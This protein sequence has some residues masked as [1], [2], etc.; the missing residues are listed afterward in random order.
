ME[1]NASGSVVNK[2]GRGADLPYWT[3]R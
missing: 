2:C 1:G 3:D